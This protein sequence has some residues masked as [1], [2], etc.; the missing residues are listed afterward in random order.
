[1]MKGEVVLRF[2]FKILLVSSF[3]LTASYVYAFNVGDNVQFHGF[4]GWAYSQ[5][6]NE[7]IYLG[8][9]EDGTYDTFNFSLAAAARPARDFRINAQ[10]SWEEDAGDEEVAID[11]AFAEWIISEALIFRVG[12]VKQPSGVY[13]EVYDV[14][15][16]RPFYYLPQ[17]KYGNSGA[18][19]EPSCKL[20]V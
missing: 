5:T 16:V 3:V 1:M 10:M 6:D 20:S 8:A 2:L 12:K 17:A 7:N 13:N 11:Y 9:T 18:I 14:G 4:G 15:T 19:T